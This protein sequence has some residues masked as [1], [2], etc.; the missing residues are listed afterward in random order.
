ME[1][2]KAYTDLDQSKKL[3]E[4]LPHESADACWTNHLFS[5]LLS[6]WRIESTPPQEYKYLLDRF[7]VKGYLIEPAWSLAAL[8]RLMPFQIIENNNRFCFYQV[9]GFNKQGETYR[10]GYKTNNEFFL[11]ESSWYNDSVDA[12]FEMI[13]WLKENGKI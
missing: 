8:L 12:A 5:D 13:C 4:I 1:Q 2:I 11:F 9:K 3:A 10:I 7:I 6:S